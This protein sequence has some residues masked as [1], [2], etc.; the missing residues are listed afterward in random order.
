MF[1][2]V[3]EKRCG[4]GVPHQAISK[5]AASIHRESLDCT[6]G[7]VCGFVRA[8]KK[9]VLLSFP[10]SQSVTV[11]YRS[12]KDPRKDYNSSYEIILTGPAFPAFSSVPVLYASVELRR[13]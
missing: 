9:L 10:V 3:A 2:E 5:I 8:E 13:I 4:K 1:E 11:L 12:Y 6:K 7:V